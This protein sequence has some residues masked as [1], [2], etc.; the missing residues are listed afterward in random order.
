MFSCELRLPLYTVQVDR[1]I[2][3]FMGETGARLRQMFDMIREREGVYLF[4]EFDALGGGRHRE[5]DVGEMSRVLTALL[6]FIEQDSSDSLIVAATN[7]PELLDKAL[8]RRFDDILYYENPL[9]A[10]RKRL[11]ANSMGTFIDSN[12]AWQ[13][14]I[15]SSDGLS[16][17]EI[18]Q[19]CRDSLKEAILQDCDTV[20]ESRLEA[21]VRRNENI[22]G[23]HKSSQS[24]AFQSYSFLI[25]LKV[26]AT[27]ILEKEAVAKLP[28]LSATELLMQTC[29]LEN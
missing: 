10:D 20:S 6:Q 27:H 1:L 22:Q 7:S 8:F 26:T 4:D 19:A 2:T 12:F 14:A 17:A 9:E 28:V 3:K 13:G 24:K 15:S 18:V 23:A 11:I 16:S 5:N 29:L 25:P 21:R